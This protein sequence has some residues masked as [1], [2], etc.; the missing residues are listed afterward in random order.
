MEDISTAIP[1]VPAVPI[2]YTFKVVQDLVDVA[3]KE[4][5]LLRSGEDKQASK[6]P[7][8]MMMMMIVMM[9]STMRAYGN[10]L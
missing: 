9:I 3:D 4:S 10:D 2:G 6:H 8:V 1:I 7:I 5:I